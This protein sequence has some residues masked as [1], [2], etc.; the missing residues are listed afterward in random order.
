MTEARQSHSEGVIMSKLSRRRTGCNLF[1]TVFQTSVI[2]NQQVGS[3]RQE[4]WMATDIAALQPA[5]P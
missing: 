3:A 5:A 4:T 1:R 2:L